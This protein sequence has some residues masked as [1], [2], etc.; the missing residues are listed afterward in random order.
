MRKYNIKKNNRQHYLDKGTVITHGAFERFTVLARRRV[1]DAHAAILA[2]CQNVLL[3]LIRFHIV[4]CG[5][6]DDIVTAGKL[7]LVVAVCLVFSEAGG[8]DSGKDDRTSEIKRTK[9]T[10]FL[11]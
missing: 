6:P 9:K 3:T 2:R 8:Q 10:V 4:K 1:V 11:S 5:F 7:H